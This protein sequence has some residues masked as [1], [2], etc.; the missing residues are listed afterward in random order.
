MNSFSCLPHEGTLL[1]IFCTITY[2][3]CIS[4]SYLKL[5]KLLSSR[6]TT[7]MKLYMFFGQAHVGFLLEIVTYYVVPFLPIM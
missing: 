4:I 1:I 2:Q 5:P 6:F 3:L 7:E